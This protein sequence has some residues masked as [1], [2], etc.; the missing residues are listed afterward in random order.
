MTAYVEECRRE[1]KRLGVPDLLA[2]EMATDLEADLV[3]AQADGVS[4][5]EILGESDPRRFAASWAGER[6]LISDPPPKKSHRRLWIVLAAVV[7]VF[8]LFGGT[9]AFGLLATTSVEGS[10]PP[11]HVQPISPSQSV[12]VPS[13]V[14]L[15][16]CHAERIAVERGLFMRDFPRHHCDAVVIRQSPAAGQVVR[17]HSR[18]TL[19]LRARR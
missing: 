11:V 12:T 3:E 10:A 14:G 7:G 19:R 18:L 13:L 6:G 17:F 4:A 9:A 5:S 8:L 1:W 16:A 15:K 2:D